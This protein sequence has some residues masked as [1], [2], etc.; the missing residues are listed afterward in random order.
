[1][2]AL[3]YI[4]NFIPKFTFK[5]YIIF[6]LATIVQFYVGSYFYK[7]S[8][9]ALKNRNADMNILV[10]LGTSI[11]YFYSLLVL[12]FPH[13]FP[14]QMQN[15]YFESC[16]SII[17]FILLGRYLEIKVRNK[18]TSFMKELLK[19]KPKKSLIE[20]DG[21]Q[22]EINSENIIK[23]DIVILR[24]GDK[25][26]VD[27]VVIE[28]RCEAN[29]SPITGEYKLV[30]KEKGDKIISGSIIEDGFC[31]IKATT[32]GKQSTVNQIIKLILEAQSKK[33]NIARL[34]DK[35]VAYFVPTIMIISILTFDIWYFLTGNIQ[36][37]LIPA[38]SVLI[39]A[40][41]CALGLAVP[42]AIVSAVGKASKEGILIKNPEIL[43][44][45][46]KI[47][48]AIFD[49]TGTLTTG[50]LKLKKLYL[51][52][53]H[54]KNYIYS[55]S[56]KSNHPISKSILSEIKGSKLKVENFKYIVGRGLKGTIEDKE[57]LLGN[58]KLMEEYNIRVNSKYKKIIEKESRQGS[59]VILLA[60][61]KQIVGIL[62]FK[63]ELKPEAKEVIEFFKDK[64][65]KVVMLTG[66][67]KIVA[68]SVARE[69]KI[70][71]YF[72]E[73]SPKDKIQIVKNFQKNGSKVMFIG[74]G[75]NDAPALTQADIA[76]AVTNATDLA[77]ETG[78][79]ILLSGNL[80]S[81]IKFIKIS[82]LS[83][84]IIRENLMWAY[85]YNTL[86]IP[87]AAGILYPFFGILIKPIFSAIAMSLS[88]VSVVLNAL[89]IQ[90][91]RL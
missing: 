59:I 75:I 71:E 73:L 30:V 2:T 34:S 50:N 57:I 4:L 52:N 41:P 18:T 14:K 46:N 85:L 36:M 11:A 68:D 26:A 89:R 21:K 51:E 17:T 64:G 37:S 53:D 86:L 40:C 24:K 81:L 84:K 60:I 62:T 79:V 48:V 45:I 47:K 33:P 28:G 76:I 61:N 31:K 90:M 16:A 78:D 49:K 54:Y 56:L 27:G 22:I 87:M 5:D 10:A 13:I 8:L 74:D 77:K 12:I 80:K 66:D 91:K 6:V 20:V 32:S 1:M 72:Y 63:D 19:L 70:D 15:T 58:T 82:H 9:S 38:V 83:N 69:L 67:S 7:S 39:I 35:I 23:G 25:A 44:I 43:E 3:I 29:Q 88:S 55:L 42:I 65:I